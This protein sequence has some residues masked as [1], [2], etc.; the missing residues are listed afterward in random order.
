MP[1]YQG[2]SNII[3]DTSE[4]TIYS[5]NAPVPTVALLS[6]VNSTRPGRAEWDGIVKGT[7]SLLYDFA[8]ESMAA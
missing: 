4:M 1:V 7:D 6:F 8:M 5:T 3:D 2:Y